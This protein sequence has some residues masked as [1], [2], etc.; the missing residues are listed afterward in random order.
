MDIDVS[1]P[2]SSEFDPSSFV[3]ALTRQR[4]SPAR[5]ALVSRFL[6]NVFGTISTIQESTVVV[7]SDRRVKFESKPLVLFQNNGSKLGQGGLPDLRFQDLNMKTQIQETVNDFVASSE[8]LGLLIGPTGCGKSHEL[9]TRAKSQFTVFIDGQAYPASNELHDLSVSHL[10]ETF[11]SITKTWTKRNEDLTQ[12]RVVGYAFVLSRMLF[13]KYLKEKYPELTPK[14]FLMHQL[15]NSRAI[16]QCFSRLSS[17]SFHNLITLRDKLIDY[18]CLFCV[19]EAHVLVAHLGDIII[20]TMEGNH[21]QQNGDV[22]ENAKRGTLSILLHAIKHG[23]FSNKVLFAGTS[24]KL[25]NV[26]N[27]GT[28]ETKPVGPLI[29]NDFKA[30]NS[31]MALNFVTS[32]VEIEPDILKKVLI[33]NYR[34]RILEN[35]VYDLFSFTVNDKDSP[36][37]KRARVERFPQ[38][39]EIQDI[40]EESYTAVIHRFTR[41]TIE[42]LAKTIKDYNQVEIMLKLLLS[43]M[44]TSNGRSIYYDLNKDQTAFF[45]DTIGSIYLVTSTT[46]YT[47]YEGYVIDSFLKLFEE[48]LWKS[49]LSASLDLLKSIIGLEGKKTSA[50]G[51]A[52][53]AV[54]VADIIQQKGPLLSQVLSSFGIVASHELNGVC[55]PIEE[56]KLED[57]DIIAKRPLNAFLRPSNQFRPDILTFLSKEVCV[58]FGI[59]IYTSKIPPAVHEDNLASTDPYL[60]FSKAGSSTN[61]EKRKQWI[62]SIKESPLK[63]SARFLF[64]F[65][66]PAASVS[67]EHAHKHENGTES[68]ILVITK[69]NMRKLLSEDV[70][71]LVEFITEP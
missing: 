18:Q 15:L 51:T 56:W 66:E 6:S 38:L 42:P 43:S 30:W 12:L 41:L 35:F 68:V 57:E 32:Y 65:P 2:E 39:T 4:T 40:I 63:F 47:F 10:K 69:S 52:F 55:F 14:Q 20:S 3:S 8:F 60:F 28:F 16:E 13:L 36:K 48:E 44:M 53:E 11:E 64:E 59:K 17:W 27:F 24:S 23:Q 1:D 45:I 31:T 21:V 49:R 37:T 19:D 26:D 54:I 25:R 22:N 34:P 58:S 62:K 61:V 33:D 29:L 7:K 50:K 67:V 46:G 71:T 70:A 5:E 9:L